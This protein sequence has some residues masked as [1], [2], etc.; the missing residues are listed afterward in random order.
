MSRM[1]Y[2][3]PFNGKN[4]RERRLFIEWLHARRAE[5]RYDP[6]L[7]EKEQ[8]RILTC[9]DEGGILG[10]VPVST[11]YVLESLAF[12]PGTDPVTEARCLESVQHHLVHIAAANQVPYMFFATTDEAVINLTARRGWKRAEVPVLC[13]DFNKLEPRAEDT[14]GRT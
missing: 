10:F 14:D 2:T 4:R 9:F 12:A 1:V 13:F 3:R 6:V 5:N 11:C 8:V 7:F